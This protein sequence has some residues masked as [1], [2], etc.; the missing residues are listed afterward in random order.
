MASGWSPLC[1][2][3]EKLYHVFKTG[4]L[5]FLLLLLF[6]FEDDVNESLQSL[7]VFMKFEKG[8]IEVMRAVEY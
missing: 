4:T 7:L 8:Q 2:Y 3:L 5:K 1:G 6:C